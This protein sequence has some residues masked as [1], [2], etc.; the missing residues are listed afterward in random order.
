MKIGCEKG[1]ISLEKYFV[2]GTK[3]ESAANKYTF[4]WKK[5]VEKNEKKFDEK[6]KVFLKDVEEITSRENQFY[7]DKDFEET[8]DDEIVTSGDIKEVTDKINKKLAEINGLDD[9]DTKDVKKKLKKAEHQIKKRL[10]SAQRKI[11]KGEI[12]LQRQKQ[13]FKDR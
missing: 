4:V 2:D 5:A 13:L 8:G 9:A 12:N 11:R 6:L 1:Y 3:I 10:S 7:G